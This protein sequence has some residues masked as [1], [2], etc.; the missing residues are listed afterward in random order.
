MN[1]LVHW[2]LVVRADYFIGSW[3]VLD[4][5]HRQLITQTDTSHVW[6]DML[7]T[8]LPWSFKVI[9]E[10]HMISFWFLFWPENNHLWWTLKIFISGA[11]DHTYKTFAKY[12]SRKRSETIRWECSWK[13]FFTFFGSLCVSF[14]QN[15]KEIFTIVW[16]L[17][18][19]SLPITPYSCRPSLMSNISG[20]FMFYVENVEHVNYRYIMKNLPRM[21]PEAWNCHNL[22]GTFW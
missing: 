11:R 21:F 13:F 2:E 3:W 8:N 16:P 6:T 22:V 7:H 20:C 10:Y 4:V 18:T 19:L 12:A 14:P 15:H 17:I 5:V 1:K 9:Q